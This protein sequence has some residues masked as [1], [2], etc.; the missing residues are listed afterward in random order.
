MNIAIGF[1]NFYEL[2]EHIEKYLP[3]Y[4]SES[5]KRIAKIAHIQVFHFHP[6]T[7]VLTPTA[8]LFDYQK[9]I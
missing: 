4:T 1:P 7:K 8:V 9:E 6:E 3:N 5:S 2:R